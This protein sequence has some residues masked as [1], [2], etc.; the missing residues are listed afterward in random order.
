MAVIPSIESARRAWEEAERE[1][2]FWH[3][4]YDDY[5]KQYPDQFVAVTKADGQFVAANV[6]ADRLIDTI[7]AN[8]LTVKQ[9]WV[10]WMAATPMCLPACS[11]AINYHCLG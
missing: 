2:A 8:G 4:H 5:L 9:V 7:K 10:R 6:D 1:D 3:E 11:P